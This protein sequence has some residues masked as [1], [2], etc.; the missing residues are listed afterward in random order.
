[1]SFRLRVETDSARIGA[2][3]LSVSEDKAGHLVES[4]TFVKTLPV[5]LKARGAFTFEALNALFRCRAYIRWMQNVSRHA[6]SL[7]SCQ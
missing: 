6:V 4:Y 5:Q 1:M 2:F 7:V 3:Q